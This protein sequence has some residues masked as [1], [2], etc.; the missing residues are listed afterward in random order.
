MNDT[1]RFLVEHGYLVLFGWVLAEQIGVPI[2]AVPILLG[3][4]ALAGMG[5]MNVGLAVVVATVAS[6]AS[7]LLWY[8]IG[9]RRGGRV[10]QLLCRISLEPDSC[11]RLTE[12]AFGRYGVRSLLVAKFVPGLNTIAPP[13]AG[14]TAMSAGRFLLYDGLGALLY[15]VTF[16]GVGFVFSEQLEAVAE[17]LGGLGAWLPVVLLAGVALYVGTKLVERRR[18]LRE[19]RTARIEPDELKRRLDAGEDIVVV[20]LRHALE[21]ES[22]PLTIPGAIRVV[23]E[24]IENDHA[25]IPRDREI[26][27]FCT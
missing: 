18:F 21:A 25:R 13:M 2:P 19:L 8:E 26:V 17:A 15:I 6:L 23:A 27:L 24:E 4:G 7:D 5:L 9:R 12:N 14:I 16:V 20:D 11:V 22:A 3:A 10:L 1:L